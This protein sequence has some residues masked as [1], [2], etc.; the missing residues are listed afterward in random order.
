[1]D[2]HATRVYRYLVASW[3][4]QEIQRGWA[5]K[6]KAGSNDLE[7]ENRNLKVAEM[8]AKG[9]LLSNHSY[10]IRS[11]ASAELVILDP[12]YSRFLGIGIRILCTMLLIKFNGGLLRGNSQRRGIMKLLFLDRLPMVLI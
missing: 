12:I 3:T 5:Y 11:S 2:S 8:A 1:V 4:G 7:K 9:L 10:G 6:A